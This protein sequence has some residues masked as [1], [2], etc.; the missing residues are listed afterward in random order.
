M[1]YTNKTLCNCYKHISTVLNRTKH[2]WTEYKQLAN[3]NIIRRNWNKS[4]LGYS[5]I[6]R[7]NKQIIYSPPSDICLSWVLTSTST[8]I[9]DAIRLLELTHT[10][11]SQQHEKPLVAFAPNTKLDPISTRFE[12]MVASARRHACIIHDEYFKTCRISSMT[13]VTVIS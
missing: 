12:I 5:S 10:H 13:R 7:R 3:A 1:S 11:S 2:A 6:A 4:P 9:S 8:H